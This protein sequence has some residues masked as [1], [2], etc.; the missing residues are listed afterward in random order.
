MSTRALLR[1]IKATVDA[2]NGVTGLYTA[3]SGRV[4]LSRRTTRESD[5]GTSLFPYLVV[6]VVSDDP[7]GEFSKTVVERILVQFS[8][9]DNSDGNSPDTCAQIKGK[10]QTL[11]DGDS[12]TLDLSAF[13]F[14][15]AYL[16]RS[17]GGFGPMRVDGV[18][19]AT[20]DYVAVFSTP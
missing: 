10:V 15:T 4:Y 19:Q 3:V 18:W 17:G 11:F 7:L 9:F 14:T 8:V 1:G 2:D 16:V 5:G 12:S 6:E 20:Q 13:G